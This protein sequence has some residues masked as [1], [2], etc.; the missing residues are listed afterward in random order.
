MSYVPRKIKGRRVY[1][2]WAGC[3]SGHA[4][5]KARCIMC[6]SVP[7]RWISFHQCFRKRGHGPKGEY[8]KQHAKKVKP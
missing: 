6:V 1:G 4:E 7:G 3:P 8:C 2:A 5:D